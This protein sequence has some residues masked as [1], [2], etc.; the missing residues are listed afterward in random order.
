MHHALVFVIQTRYTEAV[1][2]R[3]V[4]FLRTIV[5]QDW[6]FDH[7]IHKITALIFSLKQEMLFPCHRWQWLAYSIILDWGA[8]CLTPKIDLKWWARSLTTRRKDWVHWQIIVQSY[9]YLRSVQSLKLSTLR[10]KD[11]LKEPSYEFK[12]ACHLHEAYNHLVSSAQPSA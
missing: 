6:D 4:V 11:L 8:V 10:Y 9:K 7:V 5:Y 2:T 12:L 1:C 3:Q